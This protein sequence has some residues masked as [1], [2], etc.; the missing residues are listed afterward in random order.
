MPPHW[1]HLRVVDSADAWKDEL[2]A[3]WK[4]HES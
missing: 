1:E 3:F 2:A 4:N